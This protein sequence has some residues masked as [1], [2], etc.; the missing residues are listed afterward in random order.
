MPTEELLNKQSYQEYIG[1]KTVRVINVLFDEVYINLNSD[2]DKDIFEGKTTHFI[3]EIKT[4][5]IKH[6]GK[7]LKLIDKIKSDRWGYLM[8]ENLFIDS[9]IMLYR[10]IE[11]ILIT[12]RYIDLNVKPLVKMALKKSYELREEIERFRVT[13]NHKEKLNKELDRFIVST[14]PFNTI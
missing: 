13:D 12:S 1:L 5:L 11:Y 14:S 6:T 8:F 9:V 10:C 4:E 2:I 7:L 3:E